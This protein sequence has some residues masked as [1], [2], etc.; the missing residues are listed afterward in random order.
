[1]S[2]AIPRGSLVLVTGINGFVAAHV[3][4]QLLRAG[5]KV[6]GTARTVEKAEIV[7]K[8]L[9]KEHGTENFEVAIVADIT[10]DGAFEDAV[11]GIF[12]LN[13]IVS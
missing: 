12:S 7:R 6:R 9:E 8:A 2:N 3:A 10:K 11:K 13:T 5:Y 4:D 1:M